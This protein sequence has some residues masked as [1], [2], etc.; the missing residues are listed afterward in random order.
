[1]VENKISTMP[2]QV[3][4]VRHWAGAAVCHG[5]LFYFGGERKWKMF[6]NPLDTI[7]YLDLHDS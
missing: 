4:E 2:Q 7:E 1:M 6:D 5:K 3:N